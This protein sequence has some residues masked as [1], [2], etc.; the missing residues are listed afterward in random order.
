[1]LDDIHERTSNSDL[2]MGLLKKIRNKRPDLKLII[3]SATI[4]ANHIERFFNNAQKG[5]ESNVL[6]IEGRVYP[7]ELYYRPSSCK[8]YIAE[9]ARLAWDIH[10]KKPE[11]DVLVFLTGQ[12]EIEAVISLLTAKYEAETKEKKGSAIKSLM[13]LPLYAGLPLENQM[14]VFDD[15]SSKNLSMPFLVFKLRF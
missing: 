1:M 11:G 15:A 10:C 2:L 6:Y 4:T 9:S 13:L 8:N 3:S 7:V 14:A 12:E 5:F